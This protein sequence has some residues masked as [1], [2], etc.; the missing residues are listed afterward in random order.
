[1]N[2]PV[3]P[4][5][6]LSVHRSTWTLLAS[7]LQGE[8]LF[9]SLRRLQ[10]P[11]DV[12]DILP[13]LFC[14]SPTIRVFTLEFERGLRAAVQDRDF[15]PPF[16][17]LI[18]DPSGYP[19]EHS[20]CQLITRKG[21]GEEIIQHL[22]T[23]ARLQ[24]L[25]ELNLTRI[26][27]SIHHASIAALS[28]LPSLQTLKT[29]LLVWDRSAI[30][31]FTFTSFASLHHLSLSLLPLSTLSAILAT[32][33]LRTTPLRSIDLHCDVSI[34]ED[35][36]DTPLPMAEFQ[37]YL[38]LIRSALSDDLDTLHLWF[39]YNTRAEPPLPLA[40]LLAPFLSLGHLK[41]F[42]LCVRRGYVPHILDS[43]LRALI[44]AWPHLEV[45]FIWV[46]ELRDPAFSTARP[47]TV[48]G[49]VEL[50]KGCP[51]LRRVT[52][53]ALDVSVLPKAST[54]PREGHEGV[55]F[56]DM[57]ALVK[58]DG[59]AVED[60]ARV[61]DRLFPCLEQFYSIGGVGVPQAK[62]WHEVQSAMRGIQA[63]RRGIGRQ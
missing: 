49:L 53:P 38:A 10:M 46:R 43:D 28:R 61:L 24:M 58:G 1:M 37:H 57:C 31:L 47:P 25:K 19:L 29:G 21:D 56:L 3:H 51:R 34:D 60:V 45:L 63:A 30:P 62:S 52:L 15:L 4:D 39:L 11:A 55:R 23:P 22:R 44:S 8:P 40:T 5:V 2:T 14:L 9:P 12:E 17:S 41:N 50:A 36:D 33:G 35:E 27:Y 7:R 42:D 6:Q 54:L 20:M 26:M 16:L 13:F 18:S 59:V 32:S 48:T